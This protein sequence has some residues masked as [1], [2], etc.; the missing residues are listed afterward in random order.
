[1]NDTQ[2]TQGGGETPRGLSQLRS[3]LSA[4]PARL[5]AITESE[6]ALKP[7][8]ESWSPKEELGHLIDSAANNH[9]RIVR[10]QL[11]ENPALPGYDGEGW[12]KLHNYQE[13]DWRDLIAL[14]SAGNEQLLAAARTAPPSAW[15]RLCSIGDSGP[16]TL[17]FVLDDYVDHM[18]N[19]LRHIRVEVDDLSVTGDANDSAY[20]EKQATINCRIHPLLERRWS[21][22]AFEAGRRVER[23]K[24]LTLLEAARWAPS[25]FNEQPWRY[26]VFDGSDEDALK[27]ARSCLVEG[28]S[29]ALEAPVLMLSVARETFTHND[30][31]NRTAPHDVGLAS[32]NLVLEATA[33]GLAA[34]QMAGYDVE[35]ARR[36]FHIPEGFSPM[37]MIAIGY[38]YRGDLNDLSE[39]LRAKETALRSRKALSDIAFSGDWDAPYDKR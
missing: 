39:S 1:M 5:R 34:H 4:V 11:E 28:N 27:K 12:V 21:P 37:A 26:L 36:E 24:I 25:C 17:R 22:R 9:R 20:P 2:D 38:P 29:W 15:S 32:E 30:K 31:P 33:L 23:E 14:W 18:L 10:A 7:A 16:L 35:R 19:H 8:P 6:A 13:R 3:I